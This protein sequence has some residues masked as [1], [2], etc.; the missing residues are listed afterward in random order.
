MKSSL[1][2]QSNT[3]PFGTVRVSGA[4]NAAMVPLMAAFTAGQGSRVE[5]VDMALRGYDQLERQLKLIGCDFQIY[6]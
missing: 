2:V 4:R 1:Y 3:T 6:N 5:R